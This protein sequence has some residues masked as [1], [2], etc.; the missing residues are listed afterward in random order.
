MKHHRQLILLFLGMLTVPYITHATLGFSGG[1]SALTV[2]FG[3]RVLLTAPQMASTIVCSAIHGP[4]TIQP[5]N[6]A[7]FGP[8]FITTDK[9]SSEGTREKN[10][11]DQ[12]RNIRT[13]SSYMSGNPTSSQLQEEQRLVNQLKDSRAAQQSIASN[14][15]GGTPR[16]SGYVLGMYNA[17]PNMSTCYNP[18]TGT[19][20]PAF[21]VVKYGVSR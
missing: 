14:F 21:K 16:S 12:L 18:E 2:P 6:I 7:T 11:L 1:S 15:G 9:F 13:S 4:F 8:Y 5:F 3:G 19:P 10:I 20:L 17:I